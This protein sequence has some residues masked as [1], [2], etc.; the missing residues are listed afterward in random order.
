M[1]TTGRTVLVLGVL[2]TLLF[3]LNV[4]G[5]DLWPADEPRFAEVSREM[6]A[7]GDY[8][9]L[10]VNGEPYKEKPPLLFWLIATVSVPFG[11]VTALSA[12]LPSVGAAVA[13]VVLCYLLALRLY[14]A[15]VAL[16]SAV[17]LATGTRFWWQART[18][19]IDMLLTACLTVALLAFW[20][21]HE[22]RRLRWLLVFYL[23]IALGVYAKGPPAIVFPILMVIAFYW[24]RNEER[25]AVHLGMGILAVSVLVALWL[26]PARIA[27]SAEVA[28]T[29]QANMAS[30]LFR[31][32][33]GRMFLGVS[34]AQPPW[35]YLK[36]LSTDWMPW[37]FFLPWA[38]PWIW[39]RRKEDERM[40]FLLSWTVP[41]F[42]FFSICI[43]KRAQ[44][45][46]PLFPV[47]SILL[48]RSVLDLVDGGHR[49]Y[50][51]RCALLWT[52]LLLCVVAAPFVLKYTEYEQAASAG[53][54][55]LGCA[56][57]LMAIHT[58]Y[59]A[60]GGGKVNLHIIFAVHAV[61]LMGFTAQFA[62]PAVNI[63][64]SAK[65]FCQPVRTLTEAGEDFRLYS[66]GFSRE[67]Y[68]FYARHFHQPFLVGLVPMTPPPG[69][70][71]VALTKAQ[72]K[73]QKAMVK[74][75]KEVH[76]AS[77]AAAS[78][79]EVQAL[80]TALESALRE[81]EEEGSFVADFRHALDNLVLPF[82]HKFASGPPAFLFV[83]ER[84]WRWLLPLYTAF[85]PMKVVK[86]KSVGQRSV[87]L[88]ANEAGAQLLSGAA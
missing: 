56:A 69:M 31:Q 12:R 39:K 7:S 21:W 17:I 22:E 15:R 40:R 26:V 13:T 37:T 43:G 49:L 32:T 79:A 23:G 29:A 72:R 38:L 10:H 5:Y 4:G 47:L 88:I 6:M 59:R 65:G 70:D 80:G 84:D 36:T 68:V 75:T 30:N 57:F 2:A 46:L 8:L 9:V 66:V 20:L 86:H 78:P 45:L 77:F 53:V 16:W 52:L 44:Y 54:F 74:A 33:I 60:F 11:D 83:Q 35:F 41:A 19:Q 64:K 63:F 51:K 28:D 34:K 76:V 85:A 62:L 87:L 24:K 18:V 71:E 1:G 25:R 61:V 14:G 81:M 42:I 27:A 67:E 48:A 55:A 3:S 82:S 58:L 50:Q 73:V